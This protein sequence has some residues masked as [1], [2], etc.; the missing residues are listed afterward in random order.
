MPLGTALI[1]RALE[2]RLTGA[3][4]LRRAGYNSPL[5]WPRVSRYYP[6]MRLRPL[7]G[8]PLLHSSSRLI[9]L[10]TYVDARL[11]RRWLRK[12]TPLRKIDSSG[13]TLLYLQGLRYLPKA[14]CKSTTALNCSGHVTRLQMRQNPF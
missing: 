14:P 9:T 4:Q 2:L 10:G 11:D 7:I 1:C 6:I 12:A 3:P 5:N 8:E 13:P